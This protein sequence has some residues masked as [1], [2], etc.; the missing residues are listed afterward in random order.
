MKDAQGRRTGTGSRV[1]PAGQECRLF[2]DS[3]EERKDLEKVNGS[4]RNPGLPAWHNVGGRRAV[5]VTIASG[6]LYFSLDTSTF[7]GYWGYNYDMMVTPT[8]ID[9]K[10]SVAIETRLYS[11]EQDLLC[12]Q[13]TSEVTNPKEAATVIRQL[14]GKVGKEV[15]KAGLVSK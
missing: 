1:D 11:I 13:G 5:R 15:K 6:S 2:T 14:T 12:W 9:P 8:I 4:C 10:T 7:W 3:F